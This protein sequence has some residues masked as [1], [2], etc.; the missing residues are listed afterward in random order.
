MTPIRPL[1]E[2]MPLQPLRAVQSTPAEK[3]PAVNP[4][5]DIFRSAIESVKETDRDKTQMEYLMSTGQLDNPVQLNIAMAKAGLATD[6]LVTLR[7]KALD[8]YNEL[9]RI[10][11]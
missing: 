5:T 6:F 11:L 9:M 3:D 8:A 1:W 2:Q 4:F 10:S 7:S